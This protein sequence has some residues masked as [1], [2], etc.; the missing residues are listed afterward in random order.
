MRSRPRA[1]SSPMAQEPLVSAATAITALDPKREALGGIRL[2]VKEGQVEVYW[3]GEVPE[4]VHKEIANQEANGVRVE[5]RPAD[6]S[7]YQLT[8]ALNEIVE[9]RDRYP[10][11]ELVLVPLPEASGLQGWFTDPSAAKEYDFPVPVGIELAPEGDRPRHPEQRLPPFWGGAAAVWV[12]EAR[13]PPGSPS[14]RGSP[15]SSS[16]GACCR[17]RTAT[18]A[19]AAPGTRRPGGR[20]DRAGGPVGLSDSIYIRTSSSGRVYTGRVEQRHLQADRRA[21]AQLPRPVRLHR[22]GGHGRALP[23]DELLR[24]AG[25][26]SSA[27]H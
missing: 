5:L 9:Q 12:G 22:G 19:A 27:G 11:L 23:G 18:R 7:G 26:R 21:R 3:K 4:E 25:R 13:A 6:Y 15:A 1:T 10:G 16:A 8:G 2:Q 24:R 14:R 17:P 20:S